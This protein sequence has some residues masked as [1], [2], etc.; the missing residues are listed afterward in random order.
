MIPEALT[1]NV[2]VVMIAHQQPQG[3]VQL[4]EVALEMVKRL[5]L[6]P[7]REIASNDTPCR[8]GM[9]S[10]DIRDT[11]LER[12]CRVTAIQRLAFRNEVGVSEVNNFH[13]SEL[14]FWDHNN[15][16]SLQLRVHR[17]PARKLAER[18]TRNNICGYYDDALKG[19]QGQLHRSLG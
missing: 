6:T 15:G 14:I 10:V 17:C 18:Y 16:R 9:M 1:K 11:A 19:K 3:H 7:M 12:G 13:G 8:I 2:T 5:G 4:V